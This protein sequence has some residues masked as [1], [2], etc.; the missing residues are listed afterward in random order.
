MRRSSSPVW[1]LEDSSRGKITQFYVQNAHFRVLLDFSLLLYSNSSC[2]SHPPERGIIP[3]VRKA[4]Y[5]SLWLRRLRPRTGAKCIYRIILCRYQSITFDP[6]LWKRASIRLN[7]GSLKGGSANFRQVYG[8]GKC[9]TRNTNPKDNVW[10]SKLCG[11]NNWTDVEW[12]EIKKQMRGVVI[13]WGNDRRSSRFL[14][15]RGQR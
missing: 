10:H 15:L 2:N 13:V 14:K 5:G 9:R 8:T 7:V 3:T 1:G 4:T 6:F 11:I 12:E